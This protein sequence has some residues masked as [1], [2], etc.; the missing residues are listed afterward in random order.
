MK[1]KKYKKTVITNIEIMFP[2]HP[3]RNLQENYSLVQLLQMV[4]KLAII[5]LAIYRRE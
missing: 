1:N 2:R 3:K 4:F 5:K